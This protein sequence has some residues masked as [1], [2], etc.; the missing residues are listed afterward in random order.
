VCSVSEPT[1]QAVDAFL[2]QALHT[3]DA[4]LTAARDATDAAGMPPIEVSAQSGKLL[5]LLATATG[6]TR[7]LEIGTL[8]GYSTIRLA[9]GVGPQG[10]VVTLEYEPKHA[11]VA[12]SNLERAGVA[13]RV[14][15]IVGA[16]LDTL[17]TL[18]DQGRSFDLVFID[19]DKENNSAYVEWAIKLSSTGSIIVVDNVVRNGRVLEPAADDQQAQAVRDMIEMM[20][21]HPRLDTAAIQTVGSKGW[22][23]FAVALVK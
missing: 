1:A 22:D 7:V 6:A 19:A 18:A 21:E 16:A 17:P 5:S 4:A 13:D 15:I 12:R 10:S 2:D 8:G 3:E 20:G 14:E 9:R 11:E 23:G